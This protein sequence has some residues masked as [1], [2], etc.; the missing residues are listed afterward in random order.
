MGHDVLSQR[1]DD[2]ISLRLTGNH[3]GSGAVDPLALAVE[4]EQDAEKA[5]EEILQAWAE[6]CADFVRELIGKAR[7]G[8]SDH[9]FR[10]ELAAVLAR[11]PEMDLTNDDLLQEALWDASAEAYRKGWEIN[12]IEDEI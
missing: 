6:P 1:R 4:L 11:L 5:A 7:S 2:L 3:D 8:L 10:A 9:E 12:R